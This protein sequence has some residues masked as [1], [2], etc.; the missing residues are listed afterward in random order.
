MKQNFAIIGCG[1]IA[2]KHAHEIIKIGKIVA[3]YDSDLQKGEA[4]AMQFHTK[5]YAAMEDML[6]LEHSIELVSICSP[7]YLHK[8]HVIKCISA[9]KDVLCEKPMAIN[10]ADAIEMIEFAKDKN[11]KLYVVK[12]TRY[13][14]NIKKLK[15]LIDNGALGKI[16]SFHLNFVWNRPERYFEN[17]WKGSLE[18]DGGILFTQFSHYIDTLVWLLGEVDNFSGFRSNQSKKKIEFEDSGAFALKMKSGAIGT[19][20]YSINA[21][22]KNQEV[23]LNIVAENATITIGGEY[24]N[25]IIYQKP[26]SLFQN[27]KKEDGISNHNSSNHDLIY[28]AFIKAVNGIDSDIP[29]GSEG[30]KSIDLIEKIYKTILL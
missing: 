20:H 4:F 2:Q 13:H 6:S 23:S 27:I 19:L 7:N 8:E 1:R 12:S 17:T 14:S 16:Y 26:E 22:E 10:T 3:V 25:D 24:M 30:I 18:K 5:S 9:G 15:E 28:N 11:T 29:D 21:F